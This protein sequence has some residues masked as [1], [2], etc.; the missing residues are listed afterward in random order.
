MKGKSE[1]LK[2]FEEGKFCE[3][4]KNVFRNKNFIG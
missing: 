4:L 2:L 1:K 3:N